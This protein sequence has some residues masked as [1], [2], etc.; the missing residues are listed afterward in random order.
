[1]SSGQNQKLYLSSARNVVAFSRVVQAK[2]SGI[3]TVKCS[4][5]FC[6]RKCESV[7]L[8]GS[9]TFYIMFY[10]KKI[11]NLKTLKQFFF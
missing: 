9:A 3:K 5:S 8:S 4:L 6:M 7:F 11:S 2:Q 1:M 10:W